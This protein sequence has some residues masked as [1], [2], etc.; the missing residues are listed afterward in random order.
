MN[1][2]DTLWQ[3]LESAA[4]YHDGSF[5]HKLFAADLR[6][7]AQIVREQQSPEYVDQTI[8]PF[9]ELRRL[10]AENEELRAKL[11][12]TEKD[13]ERYRWLRNSADHDLL[14]DVLDHLKSGCLRQAD[15]A[16]DAAKVQP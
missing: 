16:I 5:T 11:A 1:T 12:A 10:H 7:A 15:A 3:R 6:A 13:A 8:Q 14:N 4:K 2:Q 9:A